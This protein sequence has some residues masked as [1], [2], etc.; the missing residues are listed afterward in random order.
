MNLENKK[1]VATIVLALLLGG[2]AAWLTG[3]YIQ[4]RLEAQTQSIAQE[5]KVAIDKNRAQLQQELRQRD[6]ALNQRIQTIMQQYE[7][8]LAEQ[9]QKMV[10]TPTLPPQKIEDSTIFSTI[11]PSG[12]RA[13]TI[14]IDSLSA[15]GGL[16]NP[17]DF[18][19]I[20]A[21]LRIPRYEDEDGT[22]SSSTKETTTIL[23]QNIQ[24]LAVQANFKPVGNAL[25]YQQ[26][27]QSGHLNITLSVEPQEASLLTFAQSHG[28]LQL[29]LRSPTE[30]ATYPIMS[31]TVR[32]QTCLCPNKRLRNPLK[33]RNSP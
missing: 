16:I 6:Q 25:V 20:L 5:Y 19:D 9:Q 31:R 24:V 17:G 27:Q 7:D 1:Q 29:A 22:A 4:Q 28:R 15:V 21:H 11:T 13:L 33:K 26:Q 3:V 23:F 12:K 14:K 32:G 2:V 30:Q 10:R 18:V 8:R